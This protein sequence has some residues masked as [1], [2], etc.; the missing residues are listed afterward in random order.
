MPTITC[1][2]DMKLVMSIGSES[3]SSNKR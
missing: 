2:Q 3:Y 1:F